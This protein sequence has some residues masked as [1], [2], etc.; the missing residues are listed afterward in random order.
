M[1]WFVTLLAA[2]AGAAMFSLSGQLHWPSDWLGYFC[3]SS[4]VLN[5]LLVVYVARTTWRHPVDAFASI[6]FGA[7]AGVAFI[8]LYD[9]STLFRTFLLYGLMPIAILSIFLIPDFCCGE[10]PLRKR[11][12]FA[13][14]SV[15]LSLIV[16]NLF[17]GVLDCTSVAIILPTVV[18]CALIS[19]AA[20]KRLYSSS[21]EIERQNLEMIESLADITRNSLAFLPAMTVMLL[22]CSFVCW[23]D[24]FRSDSGF[25][26]QRMDTGTS[27]GLSLVV[28]ICIACFSIAPF[29]WIFNSPKEHTVTEKEL[30]LNKILAKRVATVVFVLVLF[31]IAL[32]SAFGLFLS[33]VGH[34]VSFGERRAVMGASFF[35]LF[36][37]ILFLLS[38]GLSLLFVWGYS[39]DFA[40][41]RSPPF[42]SHL[43][44]MPYFNL[45]FIALALYIGS[46][47]LGSLF[48]AEFH[49]GIGHDRQALNSYSC[50]ISMDPSIKRIYLQ[51]GSLYK[52]LG[53]HQLASADLEKFVE[54]G[55]TNE[56]AFEFLSNHYFSQKD[57]ARATKYANLY[58]SR[59][60]QNIYAYTNRAELFYLMGERKR[61][62]AEFENSRRYFDKSPGRYDPEFLVCARLGDLK[63]A[64]R[65]AREIIASYPKH[66]SGYFRLAVVLDKAGRHTEAVNAASRCIALDPD[67]SEGYWVRGIA[68]YHQGKFEK[69]LNDL[70]TSILHWS[71]YGKVFYIRSKVY[72]ELGENKLAAKDLAESKNLGYE[73]KLDEWL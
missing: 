71:K 10:M 17:T 12:H 28:N 32:P 1:A 22:L 47:A 13:G 33:M 11:L 4:F 29:V 54:L 59:H 6:L 15:V 62:L 30:F 72:K 35:F 51:R 46:P 20:S 8:E 73:P 7:A 57:Y 48:M 63:T 43:Y 44:L 42:G 64:E 65:L 53:R 14:W 21:F 68:R 5:P 37:G 2:F 52:R 40:S 23:G 27:P 26:F 18:L 19:A 66:C 16:L 25:F 56:E 45:V 50:A 41:R 61:S 60:P 70:N 36:Y 55:G 67:Y 49:E 3:L 69:A 24:S 58:V 31:S 38:A 34:E 9:H 39:R